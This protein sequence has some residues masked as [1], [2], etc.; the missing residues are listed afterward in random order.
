MVRPARRQDAPVIAS[1]LAE[2]G[3]PASDGQVDSRLSA[4]GPDDLVLLT[5]DGLGMIA[6]HR[7]PRLAEGGAF[8]RI[9]ALVVHRD[10][11]RRGV[12]RALLHE[13]EDAACRWGCSFIEV[14]SGRRPER[15]PAHRL[16]AAAGFAD[17]SP[18]SVRYWKPLGPA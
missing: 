12:A 2:L 1:L 3:Y 15:A 9:T 16:Y 11:R 14:S 13:A 7:V 18:G 4:L 17:T 5:D 6:L 8:A 10:G